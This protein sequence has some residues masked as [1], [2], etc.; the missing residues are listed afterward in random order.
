[1]I[2]EALARRL[3]TEWGLLNP[4]YLMNGLLLESINASVKTMDCKFL[5]KDGRFIQN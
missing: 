4:E 1:M 3:P 2:L 5:F